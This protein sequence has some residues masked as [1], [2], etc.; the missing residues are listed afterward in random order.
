MRIAYKTIDFAFYSDETKE[1]E[2]IILRLKTISEEII[3]R[4]IEIRDYDKFREKINENMKILMGIFSEDEDDEKIRV[5]RGN[6]VLY[7]ELYCYLRYYRKNKNYR[8]E[9]EI[10]EGLKHIERYILS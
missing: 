1:D 6:C 8:K 2:I 7:V 9:E 5:K 10:R 3:D 4:L